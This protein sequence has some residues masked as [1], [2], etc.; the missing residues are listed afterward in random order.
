MWKHSER[1]YLIVKKKIIVILTGI[2]LITAM[3]GC[4]ANNRTENQTEQ[5]PAVT[6]EKK[7]NAEKKDTVDESQGPSAGVEKEEMSPGEPEA[8]S[9]GPEAEYNDKLAS[10]IG[11]DEA[12]RIALE[13][14]RVAETEVSNMRIHLD[15]EDNDWE[16][17]VEF[18]AGV[19]EYDYDIDGKTGQ[20]LSKD[21][22]I[23]EDFQAGTATS[24]SKE[25][26]I[27]ALLMMVPGAAEENIHMELDEE[28]GMNVFEGEVIF[29]GKEYEFKISADTGEV[30][31]WE[32]D[33]VND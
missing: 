29:E 8:E 7:D 33:S 26:A 4:A 28:D 24:F 23:E 12:L 9:K 16:Y 11:E 21:M 30:I 5:Q 25:E 1:G 13:D 2:M 6:E 27:E 14:A 10:M 22:D 18:Y 15:T 19:M 3:A 31:S 17:E 20:I 32:E